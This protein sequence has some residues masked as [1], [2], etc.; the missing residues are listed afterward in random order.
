MLPRTLHET[1]TT[2]A[3]TTL[4]VG[5][6]NFPA[7]NGSRTAKEKEPVVPAKSQTKAA[8]ANKGRE[9]EDQLLGQ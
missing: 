8:R 6:T 3:R 7:Q 4:S 1:Y 5:T 2:Q 9:K